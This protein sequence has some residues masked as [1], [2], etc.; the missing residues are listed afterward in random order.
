MQFAPTGWRLLIFRLRNG[1]ISGIAVTTH[2][3]SLM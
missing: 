3:S 1:F 2:Y